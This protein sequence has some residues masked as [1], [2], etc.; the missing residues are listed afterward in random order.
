MSL[1]VLIIDDSLSYCQLL[2]KYF[3]EL[4]VTSVDYC[5]DGTEAL[6]RLRE[7]RNRNRYQILVVDL[8]MPG[9]DGI[10]LLS[11][12]SGLEYRGGVIIASGMESR[13][14]EAASQIVLGAHLRLLGALM[15][16]VCQ[17]QLQICIE[18]LLLMAPELK[19][20]RPAMTLQSLRESIMQRKVVPYYQPQVEVG[21]GRIEGF[22]VLC[23]MQQGAHLQLMT[24]ESLMAVA[25]RHNLLNAVSEQLIGFALKQWAEISRQPECSHARLSINLTPA[26]LGQSYWPGRLLSFCHKWQVDISRVTE[27][28]TENQALD[29]QSQHSGISRLRLHNFG[30]AID[31]FGTGYTNL[32]QICRLPISELKLDMSLVRGIHMDPLAQTILKS[33]LEIGRQLGVSVVAEGVEDPRDYHYLQSIPNLIVQ[34]F[35]V[36]RPKPLGEL[37]RWLKARQR[38]AFEA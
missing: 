7:H 16:P 29:K 24:P 27:E 15:K 2:S 22:E 21:T 30:V 12:L 20:S 6:Q 3:S 38:V 35:L 18:R 31:D 23:R 34:G 26:Q 37:V 8:H 25:E 4:N 9:M 1:N 10:E 14:I 5:H 33:L 17:A 32:S 11:R 28:I 19:T 36:C 13:I